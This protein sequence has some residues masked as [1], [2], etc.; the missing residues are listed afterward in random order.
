MTVRHLVAAVRRELANDS[1]VS[2]TDAEILR[3][4]GDAVLEL[5]KAPGTAPAAPTICAFP[6]STLDAQVAARAIA[7]IRAASLQ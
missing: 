3:Q 6:L 2:V 5:L 4:L 1:A 7:R